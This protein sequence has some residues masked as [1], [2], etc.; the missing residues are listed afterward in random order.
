MWEA[1]LEARRFIRVGFGVVL[2]NLTIASPGEVSASSETGLHSCRKRWSA[3]AATCSGVDRSCTGDGFRSL[4]NKRLSNPTLLL[5]R[6]DQRKWIPASPVRRALGTAAA[7]GTSYRQEVAR[8]RSL[9]EV[10][11]ILSGS[12]G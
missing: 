6:N 12:H 2:S 8:P 5:P 10:Y 4:V 9:G 7:A 11:A 3:N 1:I